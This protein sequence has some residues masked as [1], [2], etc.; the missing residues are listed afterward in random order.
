M[1]FR[2]EQR[3]RVI[4]LLGCQT[5][6]NTYGTLVKF[7]MILTCRQKKNLGCI[8]SAGMLEKAMIQRANNERE[9]LYEKR[10]FNFCSGNRNHDGIVRCSIYCI[11]CDRT[12][13]FSEE[14]LLMN[15]IFRK[16]P[17]RKDFHVLSQWGFFFDFTVSGCR[18]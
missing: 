14:P 15:E 10:N 13:I 12:G 7:V 4:D 16:P 3:E 8:E 2:T 1:F 17:L 18:P 11:G 5:A 6:M 9:G